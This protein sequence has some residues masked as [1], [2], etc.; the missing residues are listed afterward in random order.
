MKLDSRIKGVGSNKK[1]VYEH[2]RV[3]NINFSIL[4]QIKQLSYFCFKLS[5]TCNSLSCLSDTSEGALV[6]KSVAL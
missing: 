6:I 1:R 3:L 2:R 5:F 4:S